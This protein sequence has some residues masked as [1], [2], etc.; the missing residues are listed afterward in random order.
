MLWTDGSIVDSLM[1][2]TPGAQNHGLKGWTPTLGGGLRAPLVCVS[3]SLSV[4]WGQEMA[5][6]PQAPHVSRSVTA[7]CESVASML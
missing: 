4:Q 3:V 7:Q 1:P 2:A 5:P 6:K